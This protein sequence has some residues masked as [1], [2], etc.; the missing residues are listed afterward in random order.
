MN[1]L[2]RTVTVSFLV[3]GRYFPASSPIFWYGVCIIVVL[4]SRSRI[5]LSHVPCHVPVYLHTSCILG[6]GS[7]LSRLSILY[8][9]RKEQINNWKPWLDYAG[10]TGSVDTKTKDDTSHFLFPAILFFHHYNLIRC[11]VPITNRRVGPDNTDCQR[12]I[13]LKYSEIRDM[14]F[15][16]SLIPWTTTM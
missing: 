1:S 11:F 8:T 10:F 13:I 9:Y 7:W 6:D 15:L 14:L 12:Y 5:W 4:K 2:I 3:C 16:Y